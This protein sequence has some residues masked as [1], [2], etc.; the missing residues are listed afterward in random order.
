MKNKQTFFCKRLKNIMLEQGL[1]QQ[2]LADKIGVGQQ[3]ISFWVTGKQKPTVTSLKKIAEALN[4]PLNYFFE[5][6]DNNNDVAIL[7][8]KNENLELKNRILE[9]EKEILNLIK[10]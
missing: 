2:R 10:K 9:L 4:V 7:K 8:L 5:N 6:S 1:T 3:L